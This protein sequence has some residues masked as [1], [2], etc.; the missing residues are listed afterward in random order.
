MSTAGSAAVDTALLA[1]P[2]R[3]AGHETHLVVDP[4]EEYEYAMK[5]APSHSRGGLGAD[6]WCSYESLPPNF[7][8]A[9][10]MVAGAFAGIAV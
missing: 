6:E 1:Q 10:N 8:L 2:G 9:A 5:R 4:P 7:S 3:M